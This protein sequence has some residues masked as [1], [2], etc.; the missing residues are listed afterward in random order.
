MIVQINLEK[1]EAECFDIRKLTPRECGRL[2]GVQEDALDRLIENAYADKMKS[3]DN[4][5][6]S[7]HNRLSLS[8][9]YKLFGNSI[10][11]DVLTAI[12]R[13]IWLHGE[14]P[15]TSGQ[16]ELF[17][18]EPWPAKLLPED[19]PLSIISLCSGYDAQCLALDALA[20]T[21]EGRGLRYRLAAWAEFDPDSRRP[22]AERRN[23]QN[24][25][26]KQKEQ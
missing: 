14:E 5:H 12:Y 15:P 2:M 24:S 19:R 11:V 26:T 6:V 1:R 8:S 23:D 16:M 9:L 20:A 18:D 13:Q 3:G 21:P 7:V 22:L 10:V 17:P 4:M 25:E